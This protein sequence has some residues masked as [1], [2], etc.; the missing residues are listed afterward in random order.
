MS[1]TPFVPTPSCEI[2]DPVTFAFTSTG[3]MAAARSFASA[4]RLLDGRVLVTGG[5]GVDG[6]G[7]FLVRDDAE[8]YDPATGTWSPAA[9]P[10]G[11]PR[12]HHGSFLLSTTDVL[13]MSGTPGLP[14]RR[15][16][17]SLQQPLRPAS[18]AGVLRSLPRR[19][20]D[21]ARR[22]PFMAGGLE[23]KGVSLYDPPSASSAP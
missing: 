21:A 6:L 1:S 13:V 5:Q 15:A 23:S 19:R 17:G 18:G 3:S 4:V 2:F 11:R 14:D 16:L 12:S 8:I 9:T 7:N 10:M 20:R 22:A